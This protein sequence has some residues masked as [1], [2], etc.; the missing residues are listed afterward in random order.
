MSAFVDSA[1]LHAKAGN[2][3]AG[4]VS[5][6][7]EAH[8]AKGGPDGGDG[9]RGGDVWL[10]ADHNQ[11]SLLGFRDHPFRRATDGQHGTSKRQHGSRGKDTIV[12]VPVGTTVYDVDGEVL[13]DLKGPGDRWLA[14]EGGLGGQGNARFLSNQRRAPAFAEQGE[15]GEERWFNLELK[16]QADVAL[17]GFPNV[18][19]ST[20]ISR[21]SAARPKIAD[22]PFTTLVPNLGVVRVGARASRPGDATEFVVADIPGLIEG[23]AQG[24]GLGHDFLRH[25][26][27]ARVL[28]VLLDLSETASLLPGEQLDVLLRELGEYRSDLLERP[29]VVVGS[30]GDV[31]AHELDGIETI[32]AITGDGLD[33]LVAHLARLVTDARAIEAEALEYDVVVHRPIPDEITLEREGEREWIVNGRAARRAVRFHDL[34][35]DEALAEIVHRLRELGVERLLTRAGVRDGDLVTIG[36]LSFEWWRDAVGS[37]LGRGEHHRAT[38]RER[39][40]RH[41]RLD[42][43]DDDGD[44]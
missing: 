15:V 29:R 7:R 6:R 9:G 44:A 33:L 30:K 26:E 38:R 3:G 1:Q 12:M 36:T 17:I 37:G 42:L 18:G 13:I 34:T 20:L 14:A 43:G 23:A 40:A 25:V 32:S 35:D 2:G 22:Y 28:C 27:R 41:G 10:E 11:A 16:L 19:K 24:R 39:L 8:V 5:F 4:C 21:I 31:A